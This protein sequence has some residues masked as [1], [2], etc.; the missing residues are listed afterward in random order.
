M[1]VGV[2]GAGVVKVRVT[3]NVWARVRGKGVTV[4][5]WVR[6]RGEGEGETPSHL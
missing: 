1:S 6:M 2:G 4:N 5:M 3:V